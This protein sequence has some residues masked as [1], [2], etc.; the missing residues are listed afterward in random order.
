MFKFIEGIIKDNMESN[1]CKDNDG[2]ENLAGAR[3]VK[4]NI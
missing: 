4:Q 1:E 3:Q 2:Y